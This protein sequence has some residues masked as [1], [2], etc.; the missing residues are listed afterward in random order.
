MLVSH[1]P[2]HSDEGIKGRGQAGFR[3][4]FQTTENIFVLTSLID[5]QKQTCAPVR[6]SEGTS[7]IFDCLMGVK[8][9][10]PLSTTFL[11]CLWMDTVGHDAPALSSVLIPCCYMLMTSSLCLP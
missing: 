11:D 5:K 6:N 1:F 4:D 2:K 9:G 3:K 10:C 8:Q 7:E